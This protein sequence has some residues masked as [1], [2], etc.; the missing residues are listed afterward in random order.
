[1]VGMKS[2]VLAFILAMLALPLFGADLVTEPFPPERFTNLY[3]EKDEKGKV[4]SIQ[5]SGENVIF[6]CVVDGREIDSV[7]VHPSGDDWFQFIQALNMAKV[8]KWAPD[9]TY[10]GQGITWV[11]DLGMEGRKLTTGGTNDFPK[12]G[13]EDQPQGDPKAGPSQPFQILWLAA[14]GL[15][16]KDKPPGAAK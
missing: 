8:Y 3:I 9:Y 10:P 6:K 15:V 7:T 11:V 5:L 1:M 16:G 2:F 4:M 12:E 14:M 13:A